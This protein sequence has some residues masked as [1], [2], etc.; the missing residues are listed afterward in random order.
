MFR[1]LPPTAGMPLRLT[2]FAG[3]GASQR[4]LEERR[5]SELGLSDPIVTCSG[6]AALVLMLRVLKARSERRHVVIP[7]FTC[8]LVVRAIR[9]QGLVPVVCDTAPDSYGLDPACLRGVL[10]RATLCVLP[11]H[12]AGTAVDIGDVLEAASAAGSYVLED[13]AQSLGATARGASIGERSHGA[14]FSLAAGKGLSIFEGG[15]LTVSDPQLR[16]AAREHAGQ[17]LPPNRILELQRCVELLAYYA[18]YNTRGLSLVYGGPL[19]RALR[20]GDEVAAVGDYFPEGIPLHR[21]GA[22]RKGIALR[23]LGRLHG[24]VAENRRRARRRV[25]ILEAIPGCSVINAG[26]IEHSLMPYLLVLFETRE[27]CSAVLNA[28]WASGLGVTKPFA[29]SIGDYDY[30]GALEGAPAPNARSFAARCVSITNSPAMTDEQFEQVADIIQRQIVREHR[31]SAM[32][33]CG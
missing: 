18:L 33:A 12:L 9:H 5:G 13:A 28:L 14:F 1:E 16:A 22:F 6:T 8:P 19:R 11:T 26:D 30:L 29:R 10:D 2:D 4:E 20:R 24:F 15:I 7:A 23:A 21:V 17:M 32:R 25:P 27:Q 3:R 31:P